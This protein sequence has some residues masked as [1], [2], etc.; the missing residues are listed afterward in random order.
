MGDEF[1]GVRAHD[2]GHAPRKPAV[3]RIRYRPRDELRREDE[4]LIVSVTT[5]STLMNS[6]SHALWWECPL[7]RLPANV[8]SSTASSL[9]FDTSSNR[10]PRENGI[11]RSW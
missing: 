6:V 1:V 9:I 4:A 3:R 11:E 8:S 5:Y 2:E 7:P 10:Q